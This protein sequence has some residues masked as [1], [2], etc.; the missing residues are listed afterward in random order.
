[1]NQKLKK[2]KFW[3]GFLCV[4]PFSMFLLMSV[5]SAKQYIEITLNIN[6]YK[7]G[8]LEIRD[9]ETVGDDV[10]TFD[11]SVL[12]EVNQTKTSLWLSEIPKEKRDTLIRGNSIN[13]WYK[14]DG[15][16]TFYKNRKILSFQD[17]YFEKII[18]NFIFKVGT[19]ALPFVISFGIYLF[20]T[21]KTKK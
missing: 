20:L 1:M 21:I 5:L 4:F 9:F 13:V 10:G 11:V 8:K 16:Y 12:G 15:E 7:T 6:N 3:S 17:L 2:I 18:W 19:L 14:S